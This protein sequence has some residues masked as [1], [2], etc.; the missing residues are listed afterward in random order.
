MW[1]SKKRAEIGL[2]MS[3]TLGLGAIAWLASFG[4]AEA[5]MSTWQ[6]VIVFAPV[7]TA[8]LLAWMVNWH[9]A[10]ERIRRSAAESSDVTP[11]QRPASELSGN[12]KLVWMRRV[13]GSLS[14]PRMKHAGA[15]LGA[16]VV[17]SIAFPPWVVP[18]SKS[19]LERRLGYGT[20]FSPHRATLVSDVAACGEARTN[21]LRLAEIRRDRATL[22]NREVNDE[23]NAAARAASSRA[24]MEALNRATGSHWQLLTF[25]PSLTPEQRIDRAIENAMEKWQSTRR[26]CEVS[27]TRLT[28][29]ARIDYARLALQLIA[30]AS[31]CM[32]AV[33]VPRTFDV[34]RM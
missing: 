30:L 11:S 3:M 2:W 25:Q 8:G 33:V 16:A 32:L 9:N 22:I 18:V 20:F 12:A 28:N 6:L 13:I 26:S 34:K 14:P 19:G 1:L 15:L 31:L 7:L 29:L 10:R 21:E 5:P 17:L 24:E 4:D 23:K 27:V